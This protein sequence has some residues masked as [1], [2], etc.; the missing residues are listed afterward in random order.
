MRDERFA[1]RGVANQNLSP[2][3]LLNDRNLLLRAARTQRFAGEYSREEPH[4]VTHGDAMLIFCVM[5][6][7]PDCVRVSGRL[8]VGDAVSGKGQ[9]DNQAGSRK[10][11]GKFQ[12]T[13]AVW[14]AE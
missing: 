13:N 12:T 4:P 3:H 11:A 7:K 9:D 1:I 2:R 14:L 5:F 8:R 6:G 10:M